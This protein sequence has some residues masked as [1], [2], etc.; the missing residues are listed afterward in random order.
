MV[1]LR[2]LSGI[3]DGLGD[4]LHAT[5]LFGFARQEEG[6][7]SDAAVEIPHRLFS[8]QSRIF[9]SQT[10]KL[11]CLY[12][13]HLIEGEGRYLEGQGISGIRVIF[14]LHVPYVDRIL[15]GALTPE[16]MDHGTHDHIGF[17]GIDT[18]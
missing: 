6:N 7:G 16:I 15:N 11:L 1:S 5:H 10:V 3:V 4:D 2:I 17:L 9:Q 12:G 18:D 14:F 13:I 8:G